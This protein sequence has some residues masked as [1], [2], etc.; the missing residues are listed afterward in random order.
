VNSFS[1]LHDRIGCW[2][3]L[4]T[5]DMSGKACRDKYFSLIRTFVNCGCEKF[6]NIGYRGR[7][8][9][10][11]TGWTRLESLARDKRSSFSREG[12]NYGR[13]IFYNIG[14]RSQIM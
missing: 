14:H 7:T 12:V 2:P 8:R 1:L 9:A 10:F 13:K 3:H 11:V 4:Q 5:V 6:Y